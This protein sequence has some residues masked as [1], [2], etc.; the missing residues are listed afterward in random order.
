MT[1]GAI[2]GGIIITITNITTNV[3]FELL[4]LIL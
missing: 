1:G 3:S 2:S 4:A